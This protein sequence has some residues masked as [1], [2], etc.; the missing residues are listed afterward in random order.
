MSSEHP[1]KL[2]VLV[3]DD[4]PDITLGACR[5]LQH[6]G[7]E[8]LSAAD[9]VSGLK[10]AYTHRPATILLDVRMPHMDG[11]TTLRHLMRCPETSDTPVIMCSASVVN[12]QRALDAGARFFLPKPYDSQHLLNAVRAVTEG[13]ANTPRPMATATHEHRSTA[14]DQ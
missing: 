13:V 14:D 10:L 8:T 4:D 6:A 1:P 12:Q 9:G 7:Y 2:T 11:F 3:I 5:R